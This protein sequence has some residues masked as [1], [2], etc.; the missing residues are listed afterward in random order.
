MVSILIDDDLLLRSLQPDD[1][2][3]LFKA[4]DESRHHLRPW[5][6]WVDATTKQEHILQFILRTQQQ[7]HNQTALELGLVHNREIIGGIGMHD[8]DHTLKKAQL[9]Y[10]IRKEYEGKGIVHKCLTRFIDVLFE[11]PGLNKIEIHFMPSNKRSASIASRLGFKVEGVIRQSY[12]MNGRL[13]DLVITGL[14]K[15][16]WKAQ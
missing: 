7:L 14:L 6:R 2:P 13:E 11:K 3:A 4:V 9:G 15:T 1:A 8:W 16:E 5:L 12:F 10:W